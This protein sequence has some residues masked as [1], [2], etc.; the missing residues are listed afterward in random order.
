MAIGEFSERSGLSPRR[1]RSYA[2]AGLLVPAAT[3]SASGYRYYAPGQL[4]DARLIDALRRAGVPLAEI[5]ALLHDP[6]PAQLDWWERRVAAEAAGRH[7]AL[8]D[9]RRLLGPATEP[10]S[11]TGGAMPFLTAAARSET[12]RTRDN[13]EDVFL[14]RGDILAVADGIGG[15][16]GGE[17]ASSLAVT[18]LASAFTGRSLDE[19]AAIVRASGAAI[20][21]RARSAPELTGMGTTVCV[22]GVTAE[23]AAVIANVGDSRAYLIR[24][25]EMRQ[26]TSDHTVTAELVRRGDL[27]ASAGAGHP[28]RNVLT[29]VVGGGATTV[30]VDSCTHELRA[31]D[32]LLL[33]TDGLSKV[34]ADD[35]IESVLKTTSDL[36]LAAD[37]LIELAQ[38]RGADDDVTVVVA[39]VHTDS[40]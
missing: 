18:L 21:E 3:D 1:L 2:A 7:D 17:V 35:E 40:H 39:E 9:V 24:D 20:S 6:S 29:R 13:N 27:D 11:T 38:A 15:L 25:G 37:A 22:V 30:D 5:P 10:A 4:R 33:C 36:Q 34:V 8:G 16:P 14:C 23:G 19:V 26:L 31:G 12:G 32:R 28:L